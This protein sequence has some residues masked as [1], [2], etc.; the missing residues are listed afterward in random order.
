MLRLRSI[1]AAPVA[2]LLLLSGPARAANGVTILPLANRGISSQLEAVR[3]TLRLVS[4]QLR[5]DTLV[6]IGRLGANQPPVLL[7]AAA[8]TAAPRPV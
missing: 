4:M 2:A 5:P 3:A 8:P 6:V 1:L 7:A